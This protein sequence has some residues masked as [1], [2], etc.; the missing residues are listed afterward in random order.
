MLN[1]T[2]HNLEPESC[3]RYSASAMGWRVHFS[4]PDKAKDF[5]LQ[6]IV[7]TYYKTHPFPVLWERGLFL[8]GYRRRCW[9]WTL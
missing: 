2:I 7:H 3:S 4:S 8:R 6:I 1:T 9:C 5:S